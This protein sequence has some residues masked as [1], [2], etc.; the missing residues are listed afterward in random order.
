[1]FWEEYF[2]EIESQLDPCGSL[3]RLPNARRYSNIALRI[4]MKLFMIGITIRCNILVMRDGQN[5]ATPVVEILLSSKT[6]F[7]RW[8]QEASEPGLYF[9]II[10]GV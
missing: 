3:V 10:P 5:A 7:L 8:T 4:L 2:Y 6:P 9:P 1:M